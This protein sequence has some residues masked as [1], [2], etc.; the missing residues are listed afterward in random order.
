MWLIFTDLDG[1]LLDHD[2]YSCDAALPALERLRRGSIPLVFTTS[3]T[4]AEVE[5]WRRRLDNHHPFIVEN[6]GAIF[7]PKGYFPFVPPGSVV[8]DE[9]DVIEF[10]DRYESL[11]Q[12]L[13]AAARQ[14]QCRVLGFHAMTTEQVAEC[15]DMPL[16]QAALAKQREYDEAF[17]ILDEQKSE[18]LLRALE[19]RGK[20]WTRG[21]RFY[22]VMGNS[23][24]AAAVASLRALYEKARGQ[25][26]TVG[27]GDGLNDAPFL[28]AVDIPVLIRSR[29]AVELQ[30]AVPRGKLT[31]HPG[32]EGWNRALL[33]VI[34]D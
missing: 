2:T 20:R 23:D 13:E 34:E 1:A 8:R 14:A 28:N 26:A 4:R 5:Q 22:H 15:C 18:A 27:L 31:E 12:A 17:Q 30:A 25:V 29:F 32:P 7:V 11:V 24:K 9:Y 21:G 33:E 6:G 19:E 16:E 3:K 10:G